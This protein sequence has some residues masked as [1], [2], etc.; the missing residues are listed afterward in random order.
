MVISSVCLIIFYFLLSNNLQSCFFCCSK[1]NLFII[2]L[3]LQNMKQDI[4]SQILY[5][6]ELLTQWER[7]LYINEKIKKKC[8]PGSFKTKYD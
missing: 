5:F 6:Q 3:F 7:S 1:L 2:Y 8:L 4:E